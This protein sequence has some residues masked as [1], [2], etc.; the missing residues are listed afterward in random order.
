MLGFRIKAISKLVRIF[1]R[2]KAAILNKS[3]VIDKSK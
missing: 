1:R 2:I 3:T